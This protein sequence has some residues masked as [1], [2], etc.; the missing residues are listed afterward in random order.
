L[1]K[2]FFEKWARPENA[3]WKNKLLAPFLESVYKLL[4]DFGGIMSAVDLT[5]K[6]ALRW[7]WS[8]VP[9]A[10]ALARFMEMASDFRV[11]NLPETYVFLPVY[12]CL[13]CGATSR[14]M[15]EVIENF[16]TGF[17][18]VKEV[19]D[20]VCEACRKD[21]SCNRKPRPVFQEHYVRFLGSNDQDVHI[22]GDTVCS[23]QTWVLKNSKS[24]LDV[25]E[26]ALLQAGGAIHFK[27]L[28]AEI[29]RK[30]GE[31]FTERNV[32]ATIS[33]LKE[34][35]H[36]DRGT[37]IHRSFIKIPYDLLNV[38]EEDIQRLLN[39]DV[40]YISVSG[41]FLAHKEKLVAAGVPTESAL[42]SCLKKSANPQLF[43]PEYPYIM[44]A[45][46]DRE[47]RAVPLELES[48]VAD[49]DGIVTTREMRD[50]AVEKLFIKEALFLLHFVRI[51]NLLCVRRS[52]YIHVD[53]IQQIGLVI[54]DEV[55][56]PLL[57]QLKE[58]SAVF[59]HVSVTKLFNMQKAHCL[60]AGIL[61]PRLLFS[62]LQYLYPDMMRL[63]RYPRIRFVESGSAYISGVTMEAIGYVLSKRGPC[64][65][66]ELSEHFVDRLEYNPQSIHNVVLHDEILRFEKGQ[67]VHINCL[68]WTAEKQAVLESIV[69]SHLSSRA[70]MGRP[71]GLISHIIVHFKK[72][73][74]T[75]P[76]G[77]FWTGRLLNSLLSRTGKYIVIGMQK[78]AFVPRDNPEKIANI[79]DLLFFMLRKFYGGE[80]DFEDFVTDMR[81]AGILQKSLTKAMLGEGSRIVLAGNR[82]SCLKA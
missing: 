63:S 26:M 82:I 77:V 16:K 50:Y 74:P 15:T 73:L 22:E 71:F 27:K 3:S 62:V 78:N 81:K 30:R 20:K 72:L 51:P 33:R 54:N 11:C 4:M 66:D 67:V 45:D 38:V 43:F 59:D 12:P 34:A 39:T 68:D 56:K 44:K 14:K 53:N 24:R 29:N 55:M 61:N 18:T 35:V 5:E 75:L 42:F 23:K 46:G 80:A 76:V 36:W 47:R 48:F 21:S 65:M 17:G 69:A 13:K 60:S 64:S 40:P 58:L 10:D 79:D 32:H 7:S 9:P 8:M 31:V 6:T 57:T 41:V 19:L 2:V 25:I 37:F 28:T 49:Q 1:E 52:E 70:E